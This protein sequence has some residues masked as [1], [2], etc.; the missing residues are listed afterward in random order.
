MNSVFS[1]QILAEK[2]SKLNNTQQCIETLSH[3][4]IFHQSKAELVVATWDKQFHSSQM[5]HKVR[6][7]YLANDIL[8]N[9]KRKGNEFISEFW[10]VLPAAIKDVTE[11]GDDKGKNVASRLVGIWQERRVFG[12][13]AQNIKD[14]MLGEE[15]PPPLEFSKKRSRLD[16]RSVKIVKRDS[17]SIRTKLTIG[18]TAEKIVSAYHSVLGERSSENEE[19][20]KCKTAIQHVR[21]MEED[22]NHACSRAKDPKRQTLSKE[23]KEEENVLKQC[24][25]KLKV[26]EASRIALVSHLR[27]ALHDQESELE[28][29][30]TQMQVAQA[31]AEEASNMRKLLDDDNYVGPSKQSNAKGGQIPKKTAA[32]IAAEVADKLAAS[33][34]SQYIM[35]SVLSTFAAE[36]AK[37]AGLTKSSSASTSLPSLPINSVNN[38]A[39]Q[40]PTAP[41]SNTYQ[42]ILVPPPTLQSQT[43]TSQS[44]F[45]HLQPSG[46]IVTSY[47]YGSIPPPLPLPRPSPPPLPPIMFSPMLPSTQQQFQI[48]QQ[49]PLTLAHQPLALTQQHSMSLSHQPPVPPTFRPVGLIQPSGMVYYGHTN[50]YQ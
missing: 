13:R 15:L 8:Q 4:C 27:E 37:N 31:E 12:S 40:P 11:K 30:R 33:S 19:M 44:Q 34:S 47:A 48:T 39:T 10:K 20:G 25:E 46:G 42:S 5:V 17:R 23:L 22:V 3:W 26:V 29:V 50:H 18:G 32:A 21:K 28:N 24:I 6:L 1:E 14:I 41:P 36:E 16:T 45:H 49:Q 7:L 38:M 2:L 35:S 9:S 43:T